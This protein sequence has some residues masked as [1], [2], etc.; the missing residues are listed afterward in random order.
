MSFEYKLGQFSLFKNAKGENPAR[1]DYTGEGADLAGNP[2]RVSAWLKQGQKGKFMSC[3]FELKNANQVPKPSDKPKDSTG[4]ADMPDDIP[5]AP[6][7]RGI[8]GHA[9]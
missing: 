9:I 8:S 2:I 5:F 4:F 1:P 7:G 3:K 6:I